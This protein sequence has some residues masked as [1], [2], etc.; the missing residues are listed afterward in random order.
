[1]KAFIRGGRAKKPE[2]GT[3]QGE[4]LFRIEKK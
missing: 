4:T 2:S 1:M 3:Q